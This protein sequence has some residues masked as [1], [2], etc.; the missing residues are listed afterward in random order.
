MAT[1]SEVC[2]LGHCV[3][4]VGDVIDGAGDLIDDA[5][6]AAD[7]ASSVASFMSDPFGNTFRA[8]QQGAHSLATDVL[9]ALSH[10][11]TPDLT[12]QWWVRSYA[13]SFALAVFVMVFLLFPGLIAVARGRMAGNDLFEQFTVYVPLFLVGAIFGP[14]L[15]IFLSKFFAALTDSIT[16]WGITSSADEVTKTMSQMLASGDASGIAG[17]VIIGILLML[18]MIIG[19]MLVVVMLCV[20][21]ITLY[22]CGILFPLGWV[23][24]VHKPTRGFGYKI[25]WVWIG[26]LA[27]HPLMFLLLSGVYGFMASN[28][29]VFEDSPSLDK[30]VTLVVSVLALLIAG[31]SPFLLFKYAPVMPMGSPNDNGPSTRSNS[32]PVGDRGLDDFQRRNSIETTDAGVQDSN[33]APS[34]R[35]GDAGGTA[36]SSGP[37][38]DRGASTGDAGSTG[39]ASTGDAI[40]GADASPVPAPA[41]APVGGAGSPAQASTSVG[42][43]EGAGGAAEAGS[44]ATAAEAGAASTGVGAVVVGAGLVAK[45]GYDAAKGA[46]ESAVDMTAADVETFDGGQMMGDQ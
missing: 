38:V 12:Q 19:L 31:L 2:V 32:G 42:A 29:A 17:G 27:S 25:A 26:I 28:T 9:P 44:A 6:G 8:L 13:V 21:L 43:A 24:I 46:S 40:K 10:A 5:K 11:T 14:P 30:L 22:F 36:P 20:Q 7:A 34:S 15:G 35:S 23:W 39:P 3:P 41:N 1:S 16:S 33:R 4:S 45:A 37:S 18:G